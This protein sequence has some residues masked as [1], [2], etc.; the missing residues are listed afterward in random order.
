LGNSKSGNRA[1]LYLKNNYSNIQ[2][3]KFFTRL[4]SGNHQAKRREEEKTKPGE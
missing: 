3:S 4:S 1:I 2:I